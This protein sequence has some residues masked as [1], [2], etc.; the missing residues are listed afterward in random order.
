VSGSFWQ[1]IAW[2]HAYLPNNDKF[3]IVIVASVCWAI[4]NVRN[5]ITFDK[6]ILKSPSVIIF[7]SIS[8]L[9]YWAGLQKLLSD[10][11]KLTEGAQKLKQVAAYV[12]SRQAKVPTDTEARQLAVITTI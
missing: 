2:F 6:Y 7:Y 12:Y 11:E 1:A 9:L 5:R 8:L 10:K 3:H 4:W